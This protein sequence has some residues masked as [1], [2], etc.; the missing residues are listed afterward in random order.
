[1]ASL[2]ISR[3]ANWTVLDDTLGSDHLSIVITVNNPAVVEER[4]QPH[5][6]Y[7][8]G[9]W[10]GFKDDCKRLLTEDIITNDV[11]TSCNHV[12]GA[13]L[14]AADENVLVFKPS[15]NPTRKPVLYWT[16]ECTA[17]VREGNKAKNRMQQ[18]RHVT[19][20][21]AYYK[22]KGIAQRVVKDAK[23]QN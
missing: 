15:N 8:K 10:K 1:M 20:R 2:S 7:R 21:Q 13:N 3:I 18:T 22:L 19:D 6:L 4:S 23:K 17:A 9:D 16:D 5:W 14:Q 12:V 11:T